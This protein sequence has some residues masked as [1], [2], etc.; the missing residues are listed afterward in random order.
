[1]ALTIH[2]LPENVR[3]WLFSGELLDARARYFDVMTE[4]ESDQVQDLLQ[5]T[6][7]HEL[8]VADLLT[9]LKELMPGKR[10]EF[11]CQAILAIE[12][13]NVSDWFP[14]SNLPELLKQNG[15]DQLDWVELLPIQPVIDEVFIGINPELIP[16]RTRD[17]IV[18]KMGEYLNRRIEKSDLM[19]AMMK[20]QKIGGWGWEQALALSVVEKLEVHR[21]EAAAK[22]AM[23]ASEKAITGRDAKVKSVL[24]TAM[25]EKP[26]EDAPVKKL[27]GVPE[28]DYKAVMKEE[29]QE[30]KILATFEDGG[31]EAP[32]DVFELLLKHNVPEAD[33]PSPEMAD[34]FAEFLKELE[35]QKAN[36]EAAVEAPPE[37]TFMH[38]G[39]PDI[40]PPKTPFE[41]ALHNSDLLLEKEMKEVEQKRDELMTELPE[42]AIAVSQTLDDLV[43]RIIKECEF[44]SSDAHLTKRVKNIISSRLRDIRGSEETA[45]LLGRIVSGNREISRDMAEKLVMAAERAFMEF[46]R[47]VIERTMQRERADRMRR[48]EEVLD[49]KKEQ[50]EE[51]ESELNRRFRK[52]T[53]KDLPIELPQPSAEQADAAIF[54]SLK[55]TPD[56]AVATQVKTVVAAPKVMV[57]TAPAPVRN[58]KVSVSANTLAPAMKSK[59]MDV[60]YERTLSGPIQEL[61][62]MRLSEFRRLS[63]DP[64]TAVEKIISKIELLKND[65]YEKKIQGIGAWRSSPLMQLYLAVTR[66]SLDEGIPLLKVLENRKKQVPEMLTIEECQAIRELNSKLRN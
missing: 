37:A 27:E 18:M 7:L 4:S 28:V 45:K 10:G 38:R 2:E 15:G 3:D 66:Q 51:L 17:T 39:L 63:K 9:K 5:L 23:Y 20:S 65:A 55:E 52:A 29:E 19:E 41:L 34:P 60:K 42:T 54:G 57:E 64:M 62:N 16:A 53:G 6:Y 46:Q 14:S 32:P 35:E 44:T 8:S 40:E 25:Q 30:K 43:E 50:I 26:S 24:E 49:R 33:L 61:Q 56:A 47:K 36:D 22:K 21:A 59:I 31:V 12:L 48:R 13:P 1:M 58:V 11:V